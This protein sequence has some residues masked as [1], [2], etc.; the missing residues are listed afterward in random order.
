M[1]R[2]MQFIMQ[3]AMQL[4]RSAALFFCIA[5]AANASA[6][7]NSFSLTLHFDF[8]YN[9]IKAAEV[10]ETFS[11]N[12]SGE[13]EIASNAKAL[14]LAKILYGDVARKSVG[15]VDSQIGLQMRRYEEQRGSRPPQSAET[16]ESANTIRLQRGEEMREEPAPD[17]P[18]TD[19]LTALY[20]HYI[21]KQM[22]P[23]RAA[24]TNGWRL[25]IYDYAAGETEEVQTAAGVFAAESLH[26]DSPRGRRTFWFA[27]SL[28]YLPIKIYIDDKGHVFETVLTKIVSA[29]TPD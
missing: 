9:G 24:A 11:A 12:E 2:A 29:K 18:L 19:Y 8:F 5:A 1:N 25:R 21:L 20:R 17:A 3:C 28:D 27:P 10:T 7:E 4:L 15:R 23:G 22:T 6:A 13:Y 26:R 16:N 14:G